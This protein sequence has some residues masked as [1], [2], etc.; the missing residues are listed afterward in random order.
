MSTASNHS[1]DDNLSTA[2]STSSTLAPLGCPHCPWNKQ[3]RYLFNHIATDH[4]H[5]LYACIGDANKLKYDL[6]E[7]NLLEIFQPI[8]IYKP[9]DYRKENPINRDFKLW[10]CLGCK[11]SFQKGFKAQSHWRLHK[12]CHKDH[13]KKVKRFM[14]EIE[15]KK[16]NSKAWN[17][18]LTE[19]EI[20]IGIERFRRW[21]YRIIHLD[22][23]SLKKHPLNLGKEIAVKYL[24]F[25][26]K[27]D[28][29]NLKEKHECYL[30]YTNFIHSLRFHITEKKKFYLDYPLPNPFGITDTFEEEGL[31]PVGASFERDPAKEKEDER[32]RIDRLIEEANEKNHKKRLE[33]QM[34]KLKVEVSQ[35]EETKEEPT[36]KKEI[37]LE[38][39]LE[40]VIPVKVKR[41][42][43]TI[44]RP[45]MVELVLRAT[46]PA[47]AAYPQ[48]ISN[49]KAKRAPKV[50][51][52]V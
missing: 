42:S 20:D 44:P 27:S 17:E 22:I 36:V 50:A 37:K 35:V 8:T 10:G 32:K 14:E 31:P 40:E 52:P 7:G 11:S 48:L 38:T 28:F 29:D 47:R 2:S 51:P 41:N 24:N 4:P 34:K 18:E 25:E 43:F 9:D 30:F 19:S 46:S 39:I 49:T 33:D 6:E 1:D 16:R 15:G 21:Y 3:A 26:F 5:E 23:P 12:K 45:D 13:T